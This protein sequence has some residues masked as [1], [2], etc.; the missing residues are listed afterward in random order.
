MNTENDTP[1]EKHLPIRRDPTLDYA[2]SAIIA[3]LMGSASIGGL[4]VPRFSIPV[5]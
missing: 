1:F 3:I 4:L 5:T 2:L